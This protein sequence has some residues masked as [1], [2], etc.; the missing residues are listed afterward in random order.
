MKGKN[1][2]VEIAGLGGAEGP[3]CLTPSEEQDGR[4]SR[5]GRSRSPTSNVMA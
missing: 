4:D 3:G 5:S 2:M 1:K